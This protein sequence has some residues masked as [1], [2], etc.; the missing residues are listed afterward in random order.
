M[1]YSEETAH[2]Q[3]DTMRKM[4]LGSNGEAPSVT[5]DLKKLRDM[6]TNLMAHPGYEGAKSE[7]ELREYLALSKQL[8]NAAFDA[9]PELLDALEA[10]VVAPPATELLARIEE[11]E[12][13]NQALI[14]G[15]VQDLFIKDTPEHGGGE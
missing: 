4:R 10:K 1:G 2:A 12:E 3:D 7:Q 8:S 14:A 11:L 15:M 13:E 6:L 5:V 9:L